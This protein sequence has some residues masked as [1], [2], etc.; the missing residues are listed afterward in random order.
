MLEHDLSRAVWRKSA[1]SGSTGGECVEVARLGQYQ[2]V[3]D[4]KAPHGGNL[5]IDSASWTVFITRVKRG[6]HDL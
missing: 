5:L 4:S 3:R 6:D 1:R 2:A